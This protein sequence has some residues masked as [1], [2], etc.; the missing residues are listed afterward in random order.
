MI[1]SMKFQNK[2]RTIRTEQSSKCI[3]LCWSVHRCCVKTWF[4]F[5]R[6]NIQMAEFYVNIMPHLG[7]HVLIMNKFQQTS[8]VLHAHKTFPKQVRMYQLFTSE[9]SVIL[10]RLSLL[11]ALWIFSH[12]KSEAIKT[13]LGS[14]S[15]MKG[16][17]SRQLTCSLGKEA[18]LG[19][20]EEVQE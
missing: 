7:G 1:V 13:H 8:I 9:T 11:L 5:L 19:C 6:C 17:H 4:S 3:P 14:L 15:E 16:P 18:D 10:N 12:M 20:P 2:M